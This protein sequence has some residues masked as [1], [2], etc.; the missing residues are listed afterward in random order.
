MT[1]R[2]PLDSQCIDE[3]GVGDATGLTPAYS[4]ARERMLSA[5][6]KLDGIDPVTQELCRLRNADLQQCAVCKRFRYTDTDEAVLAE[7]QRYEDSDLL[8]GR[9][10]L[11]LRLTD[12]YLRHPGVPPD[13]LR[14]QLRRE[15]SPEQIIEILLRQVRYTWN[16]TLVALA[17]DGE[18]EPVAPR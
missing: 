9:Q 13:D 14:D 16:K 11:A 10:K 18:S 17:L 4:A 2:I 15:F 12:V 1:P 8:T 7:A 6:A 3:F 5:L